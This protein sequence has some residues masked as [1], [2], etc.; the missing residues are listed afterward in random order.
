MSEYVTVA[1]PYAKAVFYIAKNS[2]SLDEWNDLLYFLSNVVSDNSIISII[3]NR[4][5]NYNDKSRMI[6]DLFDFDT[7][8]DK[9][10]QVFFCSFV[11]ILSYYGRLLC[12]KDVCFLY[13]QYMNLELD[14]VDAVIKVPCGLSAY[15]KDEIINCLSKRSNKSISA[16]FEVDESLFGGFL[17]KIGD[18]VLDA[19]IS[20][21][22]ASLS[23]KIML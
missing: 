16:L 4:T 5:I 12:V 7:T 14:R 8:F 11:N 3:K 20:G 22:L 2:N 9:K 21:N 1:R 19:S 15:Q 18:F 10:L 6:Y 13:K 17:V 23:A